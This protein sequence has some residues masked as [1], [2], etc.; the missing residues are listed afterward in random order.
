MKLLYLSLKDPQ[1]LVS[2]LR[3]ELAAARPDVYPSAVI[4]HMTSGSSSQKELIRTRTKSQHT[5]ASVVLTEGNTVS[6]PGQGS[7]GN[8]RG[9]PVWMEWTFAREQG[10]SGCQSVVAGNPGRLSVQWKGS[11]HRLRFF[12]ILLKDREMQ[13]LFPLRVGL[14]RSTGRSQGMYKPAHVYSEKLSVR[15]ANS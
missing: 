1:S 6:K 3:L 14:R 10:H 11:G 9:C 8:C 2:C 15:K 12:F 4:W 13:A 7:F 5:P